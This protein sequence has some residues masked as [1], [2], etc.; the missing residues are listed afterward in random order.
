MNTEN[1]I[2]RYVLGS[3]VLLKCLPSSNDKSFSVPFQH[4]NTLIVKD[5]NHSA[6]SFS[7]N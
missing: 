5:N 1:H 7:I 4:H 6:L 3:S 2:M